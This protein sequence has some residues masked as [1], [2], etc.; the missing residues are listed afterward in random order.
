MPIAHSRYHDQRA[1]QKGIGDG[2]AEVGLDVDENQRREE[3]HQGHD[4]VRQLV[5]AIAEPAQIP[6][7]ENDDQELA[8]LGGL[9]QRAGDV[10]P[11]LRTGALRVAKEVDGDQQ[12]DEHNERGHGQQREL[13]VIEQGDQEERHQPDADKVDLA[14]PVV[15]QVR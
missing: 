4:Q 15:G 12:Q 6:R 14:L 1:A 13:P 9:H 2:H 11:A 10:D 7:K 3:Q 8:R 5:H